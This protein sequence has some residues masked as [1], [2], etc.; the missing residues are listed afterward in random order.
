M[1]LCASRPI[2]PERLCFLICSVILH[3]P[4][5][6]AREADLQWNR[7]DLGSKHAGDYPCPV[8]GE[9]VDVSNAE[10]ILLHH[11][12]VTHPRRFLSAKLLPGC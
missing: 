6:A 8:C 10:Q 4:G 1:P 5:D 2:A 7:R 3:H 9:M 12:H 11:E